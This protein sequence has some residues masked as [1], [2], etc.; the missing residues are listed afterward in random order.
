[1]CTGAYGSVPVPQLLLHCTICETINVFL[2]FAR[3]LVICLAVGTFEEKVIAMLLKLAIPLLLSLT[4]M[5]AEPS[6]DG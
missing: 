5:G 1:M 6:S 4:N 3:G 2:D